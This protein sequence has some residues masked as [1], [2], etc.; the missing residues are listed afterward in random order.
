[1]SRV[2]RVVGVIKSTWGILLSKRDIGINKN[3]DNNN[4]N[5]N[6]N[7]NSN[8]KNCVIW[9]LVSDLQQGC[10]DVMGYRKNIVIII[11]IFFNKSF[12]LV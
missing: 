8:S 9:M 11:V 2:S 12:N 7:S 6:N 3:N 10:L 1:M 4:N 5:N